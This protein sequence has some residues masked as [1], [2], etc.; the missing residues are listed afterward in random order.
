MA[1]SILFYI[2]MYSMIVFC[3]HVLFSLTEGLAKEQFDWKL[4]DLH[5]LSHVIIF[6]IIVVIIV[7]VVVSVIVVVVISSSIHSPPTHYSAV[8]CSHF[9]TSGTHC[10]SRATSWKNFIVYPLPYNQ[11]AAEGLGGVGCMVCT[12]TI[13]FN[14]M[15][16][17]PAYVCV[18]VS[19]IA[20]PPRHEA[21]SSARL[22]SSPLLY[23]YIRNQSM[24]IACWVQVQ[25]NKKERRRLLLL[26]DQHSGGVFF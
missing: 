4:A 3:V 21:S 19:L 2:L 10:A 5:S 8:D 25:D 11:C 1:F 22:A 26:T 18:H 17:Y 6:I 20:I 7:F 23:W 16:A 15:A 14:Y 12:L 13:K 24:I 9:A